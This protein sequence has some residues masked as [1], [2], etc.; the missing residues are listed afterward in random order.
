MT[1]WRN[2]LRAGRRSLVTALSAP[3][4]ALAG[5]DH[6]VVQRL[7]VESRI[8]G[9]RR[10]VDVFLPRDYA[11][12]TAA[13]YPVIYAYDGQDMD[14]VHLAD[15]L[16]SLQR[17]GAMR[18]V[19]VVAV[20]AAD[21]LADY[22]TAGIPNAQ[23]RGARAELYSRFLLEE[24]MPKIGAGYRVAP[25]ASNTALMGWSL[26]GL[27]A[28]DLAWRHPERIGAVGAFSASFWWRT[29]D[30]DVATRQSSRIMHRRVRG[31]AVRP[32]IRIWLESGLQDETADRDGDGVI[33]SIQDSEE[34]VNELVTLGFRRG[35]DLVHLTVTGKHDLPT[36]SRMIPEFLVWAF[37]R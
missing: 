36:W 13:S 6:V 20:H 37:P 2:L 4:L 24:L 3:A 22:G 15:Q 26:G 28:F 8:L 12:A 31:T 32:A 5:R 17:T 29:D 35:P 30:T 27:A 11:N 9:E 19:I 7:L 16:D 25:G 34:L 1:D 21:R 14:S 10:T 23:G 18:P 33:D